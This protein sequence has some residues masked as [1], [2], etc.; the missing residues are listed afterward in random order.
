MPKKILMVA[1]IIV[2]SLM[3]QN[4]APQV[5]FTQSDVDLSSHIDTP[6]VCRPM[7]A[8][9]VKPSLAFA[10]NHA[11][12]VSPSYN[13]VMAT[14][15]VG[16]ID[17]DGI[18]EI[19]FVSYQ[20]DNYNSEGV[21]RVISGATGLPKFSITADSTRPF[22][23]ATPLLVDI[24]GDGKAEIFY[25]HY[26]QRKVIALNHDG[27][28][29]WEYT[30]DAPIGDCRYGFSA[31]K[32]ASNGG[33]QII[34]GGYI[35]SEDQSRRPYLFSK[36]SEQNSECAVYAAS[37]GTEKNSPHKIIGTSGVYDING[38]MLWSYARKGYAA[39]A[40]IRP[41]V[42]GVEVVV[43]GSGYFAIYNGL[44]G[45]VLVDKTLSEHSE[46]ICMVNGGGA[47]IGG[48]QASIGD[49]DGNP[50][51]LEVAI[52]T[53]KSLTVFDRNGN[54]IAGSVTQ[55]CSSLTTGITS[56]DF[57]GDGKP[58]I[59]YADEQY[60]RIYEIRNGSLQVVWS[61]VN[62]SA[63]LR[64][65]PVVADV[66]GDGYAELVVVANSAGGN[67][68]KGVRVFKPS[69]K[70]SWM[71]TRSVWN[72]HNYYSSNVNDDLTATASSNI[73]G[74]TSQFFKRNAQKKHS[75]ELCTK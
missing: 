29:R 65:Y 49:F 74:F 40:D 20:D 71:P 27:S 41:D 56:F 66:N 6:P 61:A 38:N 25:M 36:N 47:V 48:G 69:S 1:S 24:D 12:D 73:D 63:T 54:K 7:D 23:S 18:P 5:N 55:D 39:T 10:W 67:A 26:Q 37:L 43:T 59:I 17:K 13:Q 42:P 45:Q 58:E 11:Q 50:A 9:E 51:T 72:Q 14:P 21:L 32:L 68:I 33:T 28:F 15:V 44:T 22:A 35:I 2:L 46:L 4:C 60:I 31:A 16:D 52:A 75:T 3:Y 34:A 8:A 64:E 19:A 70:G 62:P 53:G 30:L 57:N